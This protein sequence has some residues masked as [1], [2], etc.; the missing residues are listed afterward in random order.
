MKQ[1]LKCFRK[2]IMIIKP[3]PFPLYTS[4]YWSHKQ[5]CDFH[6]HLLGLVICNRYFIDIQLRVVYNIPIICIQASRVQ[7]FVVSFSA[8]QYLP[9]VQNGKFSA[10]AELFVRTLKNVDF[11]KNEKAIHQRLVLVDQT[12]DMRSHVRFSALVPKL[13]PH[14]YPTFGK[15]TIPHLSEVPNLPINGAGFSSSFFFGG[16]FR[17]N[18]Q[19][20]QR[21]L[22][23]T[24][25][26]Q[27]KI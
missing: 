24:D 2:Q 11:L 21:Y 17:I 14:S 18:E 12:K 20:N 1:P 9:I 23:T 25:L 4:T 13:L 26:P 16:I 27:Q 19:E 10:A 6:Y 8:T 15:P 3:P 5:I 22:N 7:L